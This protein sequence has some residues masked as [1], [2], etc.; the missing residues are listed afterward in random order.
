MSQHASLAAVCDPPGMA[1]SQPGKGQKL[2][3][4]DDSPL[5]LGLYQAV[6]ESFG[7]EVQ[8]VCSP[9]EALDYLS[10]QAIDAAI[11]DYEMPEMNGGVLA[12]F[13]KARHPELP[14]IL[15][16][17][18]LSISPEAHRWVDAICSKAAPRERLLA[19]IE[20]TLAQ[21]AGRQKRRIRGILIARLKIAFTA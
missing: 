21:R 4:V 16:T 1:E 13:I 17:G 19:T 9:R 3:W 7:F 18:S 6:F 14:V 20:E 12:S 10:T 5:L 11:L 2:L 8:A 15:Y